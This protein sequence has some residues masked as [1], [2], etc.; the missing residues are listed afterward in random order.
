MDWELVLKILPF[1]IGAVGTLFGAKLVGWLDFGAGK[2]TEI[3]K[4][5]TKVMDEMDDVIPVLKDI[6]ADPTEEKI[7]AAK[8]EIVEAFEAIVKIKE[9]LG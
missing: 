5:I 2:L 7:L 1:V 4:W 6:L 8:K 3:T 9:I